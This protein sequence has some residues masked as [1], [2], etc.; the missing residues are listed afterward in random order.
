MRKLFIITGV[1][2]VF[3]MI[4]NLSLSAQLTEKEIEERP[5]WE[6]FLADAAVLKGSQPLPKALAVSRPHKLRLGKDGVERWGWWKNVTGRPEGYSDEWR[7]EVAAYELDKLLGLNMIPPTVEKRYREDRGAISLQAEGTL[8]REL[9]AQKTSLPSDAAQRASFYKALFLRRTWDNLLHNKD[10][11]EGDMIVTD[12]WRMYLIDHS[13]AFSSSKDLFHKPKKGSGREPIRS[14]PTGFVENLAA[15]DYDSIKDT[16]GDYLTKKEIER[17]L[18]RR[19]KILEE[20]E[21][22][23]VKIP[24]FLY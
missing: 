19:D 12:D 11:N 3:F 1:W 24:D 20:V 23:K 7:R 17:L 14:L 13:R 2:L 21:R 9:K 15:L 18:V 22:L 5:Q 6:K 16:V 10:R 4:L 8:Y